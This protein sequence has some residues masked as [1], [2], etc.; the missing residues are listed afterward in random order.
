MST[1]GNVELAKLASQ[2]KKK[3]QDAVIEKLPL[4][5]GSYSSFTSRLYMLPIQII[6]ANQ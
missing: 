4:N 6:R 2:Q 3:S 5:L 1:A